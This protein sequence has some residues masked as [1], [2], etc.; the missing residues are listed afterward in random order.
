MRS[1]LSRLTRNREVSANQQPSDQN[2]TKKKK[3]QG[4]SRART[5]TAKLKSPKQPKLNPQTQSHPANTTGQ[6]PASVPPVHQNGAAKSPITPQSINLTG[7]ETQDE[8]TTKI[9]RVLAQK[10]APDNMSMNAEL[11]NNFVNGLKLSKSE[12][13]DIILKVVQKHVD[14]QANTATMEK[15]VFR[16]GDICSVAI[17]EHLT[18]EF[19]QSVS[20]TIAN[21]MTTVYH[22]ANEKGE[23]PNA[24]AVKAGFHAL[25]EVFQSL[26]DE[27]RELFQR[28]ALE[29]KAAGASHPEFKKDVVKV[30]FASLIGIKGLHQHLGA[31]VMNNLV[32]KGYVHDAFTIAH[33]LLGPPI[34]KTV[35]ALITE[36]TTDP[37]TLSEKGVEMIM[38]GQKFTEAEAK[39]IA[40]PELIKEMMGV[41]HDFIQPP[42][43]NDKRS[44]H[45]DPITPWAQADAPPRGQSD[46]NVPPQTKSSP[47]AET[48]TSSNNVSSTSQGAKNPE[49]DTLGTPLSEK[50]DHFLTSTPKVIIG[51]V[52]NHPNITKLSYREVQEIEKMIDNSDYNEIAVANYAEKILNSK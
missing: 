27:I 38:I 5:W 19:N 46:A 2:T 51:K 7:N 3:T 10:A 47:S 23:D 52:R 6:T 35:N 24:A 16:N 1:L 20:E 43:S 17:S 33:T 50:L 32:A 41:F 28:V 37:K 31:K 30:G 11:F 40:T 8:K 25:I 48:R 45:A 49:T 29:L 42:A 39:S 12:I 21:R 9:A 4:Q 36:N 18:N 14:Q 34:L 15:N 44:G 13:L 26:P 22:E